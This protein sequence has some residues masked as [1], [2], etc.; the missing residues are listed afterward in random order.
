M[1]ISVFLTFSLLLSGSLFGQF[2]TLLGEE[3]EAVLLDTLKSQEAAMVQSLESG[4]IKV[5][6]AVETPDSTALSEAEMK[7]LSKHA[8]ERYEELIAR[9][10]SLDQAIA[11]SR[12]THFQELNELEPQPVPEVEKPVEV[13]QW[14]EGQEGKISEIKKNHENNATFEAWKQNTWYKM[15]AEEKDALH[16]T[17]TEEDR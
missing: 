15:T 5:A 8:A 10:D 4:R 11:A 16:K 14:T 2:D 6:E 7:A 3:K 1:K 17:K 9:E 12:Q 13:I